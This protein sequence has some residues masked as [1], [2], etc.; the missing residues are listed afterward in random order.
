MEKNK[1]LKVG[2]SC[3]THHCTI[4]GG[5]FLAAA[6]VLTLLTFNGLGIFGMFVVGALFCCHKHMNTKRCGCGCQCCSTES[7]SS[8]TMDTPKKTTSTVEKKVTKK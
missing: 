5:L 3:N 6:T 7:T 2:E 4:I 8:C 1:N